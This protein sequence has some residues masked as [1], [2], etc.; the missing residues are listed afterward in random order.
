MEG[1]LGHKDDAGWLARQDGQW[2]DALRRRLPKTNAHQWLYAQGV[3]FG[4]LECIGRA[5]KWDVPSLVTRLVMDHG[6]RLRG[7]YW[8]GVTTLAA[9]DAMPQWPWLSKPGAEANQWIARVVAPAFALGGR[10]IVQFATEV[11]AKYRGL[12]AP[13]AGVMATATATAT[14]TAQHHPQMEPTIQE[15][16]ILVAAF[17]AASVTKPL[18]ALFVEA[19]QARDYTLMTC[20]VALSVD[21][22][23]LQA[24][25]TAAD[26]PVHFDAILLRAAAITANSVRP[27]L[28]HVACP[29]DPTL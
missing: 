22:I 5:L 8:R 6:V 28:A 29:T 3:S 19:V 25:A 14:A 15:W 17:Q 27:R 10:T 16:L 1:L 23:P 2:W 26:P 7:D 9:L 20:L 12:Q 4:V 11:R 24:V 21:W 18:P 13:Q